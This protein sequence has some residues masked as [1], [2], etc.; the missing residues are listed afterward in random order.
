MSLIV[1]TSLY[2]PSGMPSLNPE[3]DECRLEYTT[4]S[5]NTLPAQLHLDF[6]FWGGGGVQFERSCSRKLAHYLDG[7]DE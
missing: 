4:T 1:L 5:W 2:K 6:F 3:R 7:A